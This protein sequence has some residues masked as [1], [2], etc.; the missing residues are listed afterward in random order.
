M[1]QCKQNSMQLANLNDT[2]QTK[3]HAMKKPNLNKM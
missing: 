2:M 3:Q 1:I